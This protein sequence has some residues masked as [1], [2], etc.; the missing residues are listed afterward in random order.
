ME[1][2]KKLLKEHNANYEL[3]YNDKKIFSIDDGKK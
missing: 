1:E 2:I 3:I